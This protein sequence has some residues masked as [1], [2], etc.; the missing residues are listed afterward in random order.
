MHINTNYIIDMEQPDLTGNGGG[1]YVEVTVK[2]R[3]Y[4]GDPFNNK[5]IECD[6]NIAENILGNLAHYWDSHNFDEIMRFYREERRV[7]KL[8]PSGNTSKWGDNHESN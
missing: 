8:A 3:H 6:F 7:N 5:T 2:I 1:L 4:F